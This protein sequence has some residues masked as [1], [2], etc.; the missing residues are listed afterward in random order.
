LLIPILK[1]LRACQRP[2]ICIDLCS[3]LVQILFVHAYVWRNPLL[4]MANVCQ[5]V[6]TIKRFSNMSRV[7]FLDAMMTCHY[8]CASAQKAIVA[9]IRSC[10]HKLEPELSKLLKLATSCYELTSFIDM[11]W[12]MLCY[13]TCMHWRRGVA[14]GKVHPDEVHVLSDPCRQFCMYVIMRIESQ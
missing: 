13:P 4:T 10:L 14:G 7:G 8:H 12:G 9:I 2:F 11:P 1:R 6:L 3:A 5:Q